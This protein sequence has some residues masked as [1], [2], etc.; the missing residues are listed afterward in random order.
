MNLGRRVRDHPLLSRKHHRDESI[1]FVFLFLFHFSVPAQDLPSPIGSSD[2]VWSGWGTCAPNPMQNLP[3][4]DHLKKS[5]TGAKE[6]RPA[7][8]GSTLAKY[9]FIML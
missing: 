8:K 1:C 2:N 6:F 5:E 4:N 7:M 3:E 9:V